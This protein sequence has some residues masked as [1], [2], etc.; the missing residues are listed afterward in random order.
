[1]W[2]A[3]ADDDFVCVCSLRKSNPEVFQ[4]PSVYIAVC[5]L[6]CSYMYTLSARRL[7]HSVFDKV[8]F[9]KE[10]DWSSLSTS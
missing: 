7:L 3:M 2:W 8:S 5:D 10:S 1:M 4:S 9:A 6:L